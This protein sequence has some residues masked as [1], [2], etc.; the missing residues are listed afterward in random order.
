MIPGITVAERQAS[1]ADELQAKI[2]LREVCISKKRDDAENSRF[3][4]YE[5][6]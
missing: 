6:V 2:S 1:K 5:A 4:G 3:V